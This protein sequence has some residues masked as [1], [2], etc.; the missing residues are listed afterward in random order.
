MEAPVDSP[1]INV[2]VYWITKRSFLPVIFP[3][4]QLRK[5]YTNHHDRLLV[6]LDIFQ[7]FSGIIWCNIKAINFGDMKV[8]YTRELFMNSFMPL[9]FTFLSMVCCCFFPCFTKFLLYLVAYLLDSIS[10]IW[11]PPLP[12]C[13][14]ISFLKYFQSMISW[15]VKTS[16]CM[17][18]L[19]IHTYILIEDHYI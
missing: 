5:S 14:D 12:P 13:I 2:S 16:S 19:W 3:H 1:N 4:G 8:K 18:C 15:H 7:H 17:H 11:T 10:S 9:S 6:N